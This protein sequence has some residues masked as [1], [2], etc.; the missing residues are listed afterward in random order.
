[1]TAEE[2]VLGICV[3]GCVCVFCTQ[4]V[5]LRSEKNINFKFL[6]DILAD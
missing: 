6:F 3:W 2:L 1:M 4:D 5:I